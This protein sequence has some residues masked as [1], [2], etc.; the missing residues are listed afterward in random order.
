[1]TIRKGQQWGA[2]RPLDAGGVVVRGDRQAGEIVAAARRSRQPIPTLGLVGGDLARALGSTGDESRLHSS[3]AHTFPVD[4]GTV[5][6]DDHLEYFVA[7]LVAR[8]RWWAGRF[9]VAMN[10]EYLGQW[11]IAPRAHP[12]DG[13]LDIL[14]GSLSFDDRLKARARL[15]RGDHLPHP[16]IRTQQ[17]AAIQVEFAAPTPIFLDGEAYGRA[18]A[19]SI[20]VE[21]DAL[22]CVV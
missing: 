18:T 16:S 3:A 2:P 7:H 19:L 5:L 22:R 6:I 9:F 4:L 15:A 13:R 10:S 14:D 11:K 20:R 12:N 21:P 1:V 8:R 17:S